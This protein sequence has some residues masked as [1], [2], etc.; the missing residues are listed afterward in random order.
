VAEAQ[1]RRDWG[2]IANCTEKVGFYGG[3]R[4]RQLNDRRS[5]LE[6]RCPSSTAYSVTNVCVDLVGF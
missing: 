2:W 4:G 6:H 3:P 1:N 5:D